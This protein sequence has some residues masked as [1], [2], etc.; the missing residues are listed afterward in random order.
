M[1]Y[2]GKS[3][4]TPA[5][6]KAVFKTMIRAYGIGW[7]A[8]TVPAI[9]SLLFRIILNRQQD[10]KSRLACIQ[11]A[12]LVTLPH[13]LKDSILRNGFPL[14]LAG[15]LS[16]HHF[17]LQ[18]QQLAQKSI[19][20]AFTQATTTA[21]TECVLNKYRDSKPSFVR[22]KSQKSAFF[23]SAFISFCFVR[24][25]F[26]SIKTLDLTLFALVRAADVYA[27]RMYA[28]PKSRQIVPEWILEYGNVG[29]FM[30][31]CAEIMYTWFYRPQ[32]LPRSYARWIT[33]MAGIDE[34]LKAFL[35]MVKHNEI[36]YG[37]DT[38]L[39]HFLYNYCDELK[40][41]RSFGDPLTGRVH[42]AVAH[43]GSRWGCEVNALSRFLKGFKKI[44][45][46]NLFLHFAPLLFFRTKQ[47]VH[48]PS[49]WIVHAL[50][51]TVR[52]SAFLGTFIAI[53][54]YCVCLI[55]TRIGYRLLKIPQQNLDSVAPL[56]GSMLCGLSLLIESKHRRGEMV[57]YVVPRALFSFME[58]MLPQRMKTGFMAEVIENIVF[59]ASV[60][61]LL[62][63]MYHDTAMVR[64]SIRGLLSWILKDEIKQQLQVHAD[65]ENAIAD[66][67]SSDVET[68]GMSSKC[69]GEKEED[70][71]SEEEEAE[72]EIHLEILKRKKVAH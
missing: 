2:N 45:T 60:R 35:R 26:P 22:L 47:L 42:C 72:I 11:K 14:L 62:A 21:T 24:R 6:P 17:L 34:R 20:N 18:Q 19:A 67:A 56:I 27:H 4:I 33:D 46:V 57:L 44:F 39:S 55:R 10:N 69:E 32:K 65:G 71:D 52:S 43:E 38:G 51:A 12:C 40:L 13:I 54:W 7:A 50:I 23:L 48:N 66:D 36:V 59:S 49:R 58:R 64:P 29:V 41:P 63:A 37:K 30:L 25:L 15:A 70:V 16:G 9:S 1:N 61:V 28:S 31:A 3:N 5:Q 53:I 8:T 68:L